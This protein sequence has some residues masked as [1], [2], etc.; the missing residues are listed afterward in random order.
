[1][2]EIDNREELYKKGMDCLFN[3]LGQLGAT[4]FIQILS[5]KQGN[6]TEWRKSHLYPNMTVDQICDMIQLKKQKQQDN[7]KQLQKNKLIHSVA[8]QTVAA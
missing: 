6:Y 3:S 1:M 2:N 4:T 5:S 7:S 8:E